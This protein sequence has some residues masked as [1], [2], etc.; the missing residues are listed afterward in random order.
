MMQILHKKKK[1]DDF[2][3]MRKTIDWKLIITWLPNGINKQQIF[4]IFWTTA[5]VSN[6]VCL[7]QIRSEKVFTYFIGI[8]VCVKERLVLENITMERRKE[9]G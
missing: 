4:I 2:W 8:F 1:H 9:K 6:V 7:K 3:I 5:K